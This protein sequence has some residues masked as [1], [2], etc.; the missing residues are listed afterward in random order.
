MLKKFCLIVFTILHSCNEAKPEQKKETLEKNSITK[1]KDSL[2]AENDILMFYYS[3]SSYKFSSST[4]MND[5]WE[6]LEYE[7][8]KIEEYKNAPAPFTPLTD[9]TV[10]VLWSSPSETFMDE[11]YFKTISN[12]ERAALGYLTI[13]AGSWSKFNIN[14]NEEHILETALDLD[15]QCSTKYKYYMQKWFKND[16]KSLEKIDFC[17]T[18]SYMA[19]AQQNYNQIILRISGNKIYTYGKIEGINRDICGWSYTIK[20]TFLITNNSIKVINEKESLLEYVYHYPNGS[21]H[22]PP[23]DY[24][25]NGKGDYYLVKKSKRK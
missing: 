16:S 9:K 2:S 6:E 13:S 19:S 21:N 20:T 10:K 25:D 14:R 5:Y 8:L 17:H 24:K 15:Y 1:K 18:R 22:E 4:K 23:P 11:M 12:A 3:T 7:Y